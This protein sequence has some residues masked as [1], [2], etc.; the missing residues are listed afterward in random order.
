MGST[1]RSAPDLFSPIHSGGRRG[2]YQVCCLKLCDSSS[3]H[4]DQ[5]SHM[6]LLSGPAASDLAM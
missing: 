3:V 6:C 5:P 4:W 2:R 1:E